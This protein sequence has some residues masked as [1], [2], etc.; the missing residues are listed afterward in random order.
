M[1]ALRRAVAA[2]NDVMKSSTFDSSAHTVADS[3]SVFEARPDS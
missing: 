3:C 1:A 2:S